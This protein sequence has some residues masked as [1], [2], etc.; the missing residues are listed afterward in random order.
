MITLL[1][2]LKEMYIDNQGNLVGEADFVIL[3][4]GFNGGI[5]K[6][7]E[8]TNPSDYVNFK[9]KLLSFRKKDIANSIYKQILQIYNQS[10]LKK[11]NETIGFTPNLEYDK[12]DGNW[13]ESGYDISL[14][15]SLSIS[16]ILNSYYYMP[17]TEF[18]KYIKKMRGL[19]GVENDETDSEKLLNKE[20]DLS[21]FKNFNKQDLYNKIENIP[22]ICIPKYSFAGN[23]ISQIETNISTGNDSFSDQHKLYSKQDLLDD[24]NEIGLFLI[25]E[26]KKPKDIDL[27]KTDFTLYIVKPDAVYT[28]HY[29]DGSGTYKMQYRDPFIVFCKDNENWKDILKKYYKSS[30]SGIY[31]N[32]LS[33]SVFIFGGEA[34]NKTKK[35]IEVSIME[36]NSPKVLKYKNINISR[37]EFNKLKKSQIYTPS[38]Y[39]DDSLKAKFPELLNKL[40][41]RNFK[42]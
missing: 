15:N 19:M 9:T 2:I 20:K 33:P 41:K 35:G 16:G 37:E 3:E 11:Y 27:S 13:N 1:D 21:R 38:E 4:G 39:G 36:P 17:A 12:G 32:F 18:D 5:Y 22:V 24:L 6:D 14:T 40:P 10:S 26:N 30:Y 25:S 7:I 31:D 42:N 8:T 29:N 34:P 28:G 23:I